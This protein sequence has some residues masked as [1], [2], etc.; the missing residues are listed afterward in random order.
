MPPWDATDVG[1]FVAAGPK[2]AGVAL[3]YAPENLREEDSLDN[4]LCMSSSK[5][6]Y[7]FLETSPEAEIFGTVGAIF[8]PENSEHPAVLVPI[9]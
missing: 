7:Y 4:P 1:L 5:R 8:W 3:A 2:S 9:S 6:R